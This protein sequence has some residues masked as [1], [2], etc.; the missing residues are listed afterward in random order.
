MWKISL[1][2]LLPSAL[3]QYKNVHP[4]LEYAF[5]EQI[6]PVI[7]RGFAVSILISILV[8]LFSTLKGYNHKKEAI[9]EFLGIVLI[10][11]MELTWS[12]LEIYSIYNG[13]ILV[14]FGVMASLLISKLIICSVTKVPV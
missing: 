10:A 11:A 6:G 13:L 7:V 9:Y 12:S 5:T 8:L 14:N 4:L 3:T 2:D 1:S